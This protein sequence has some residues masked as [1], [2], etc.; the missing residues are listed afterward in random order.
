MVGTHFDRLVRAWHGAGTRRA[1]LRVL[2]ALP[3]GGV[4]ALPFDPA[5]SSAVGDER[6]S[7]KQRCRRRKGKG[8]GHHG[9]RKSCKAHHG[10]NRKNKSKNKK[11][12]QRCPERP[13]P[14]AAPICDASHTCVPCTA[15]SHCGDGLLCLENGQCQACDVTCDANDHTCD[16]TA[17]QAVL[18]ASDSGDTVYICPGRY[19]GT[20]VLDT[21]LTLIGAGQGDDPASDTI[22]DARGNGVVVRIT[23]QA[24]STTLRRLRVTGGNSLGPPGAISDDGGDL[25]MTDC[26]VSE[27]RNGGIGKFR[28]GTLQLTDCTVSEN[29]TSG[30]GTGLHLSDANTIATLTNCT[31]S[32]NDGAGSGGGIFVVGT[33]TLDNSSVTGNTT[34]GDG[35]GIFSISG[36]VHL[37]N[38]SI[39]SGNTAASEGGGIYNGHSSATDPSTVTITD[40]DITENRA[41]FGS[42]PGGGIFNA[43]TVVFTSGRIA[44]NIPDDCVNIAPAGEGCPP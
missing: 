18:D 26:T 14:A 10:G 36:K 9:R 43:R 3:L 40:S 39:I 22:F 7:R 32:G 2:A 15:H 29:S 41:N 8:K 38:G 42:S 17:M 24:T 20:F 33:L 34:G 35:G 30:G 16:R 1:V 27:N 25:T 31:I 28:A 6:R 4:A 44:N 23:A 11:K 37:T 12:Q 5:L 19:T 13:C 21:N